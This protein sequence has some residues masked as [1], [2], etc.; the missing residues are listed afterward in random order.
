[1]N[2]STRNA[3]DRST[4]N[5]EVLIGQLAD[6]VAAERAGREPGAVS[7]VMRRAV[8]AARLDAMQFAD[9][10]DR[11]ADRLAK[12]MSALIKALFE[13]AA[14]KDAPIALCAVGGFGRAGSS[15]FKAW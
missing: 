1:M 7:A 14:P 12:S 2:A 11:I 4:V 3:S 9:R 13:I 5:R 10:G 15:R 6:A 8:A